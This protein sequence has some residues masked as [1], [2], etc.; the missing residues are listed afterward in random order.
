MSLWA[1]NLWR[2]NQRVSV[3]L[4]HSIGSAGD[5]PHF[6]KRSMNSAQAFRLHLVLF[7]NLCWAKT[8]RHASSGPVHLRCKASIISYAITGHVQL[9][10]ASRIQSCGEK[11]PECYFCWFGLCAHFT[12]VLHT[13][14]YTHWHNS[15]IFLIFEHNNQ[16]FGLW[17]CWT[18]GNQSTWPIFTCLKSDLHVWPHWLQAYKARLHVHMKNFFFLSRQQTHD[19]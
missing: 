6:V 9:P 13:S 8:Q 10:G 14:Y 3:A 16:D 1:T 15:R 12:W 4:L 2:E 18:H 11:R 17:A 19:D 5:V 7:Y